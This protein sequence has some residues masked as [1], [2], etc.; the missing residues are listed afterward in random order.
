MAVP[1]LP[2]GIGFL[3]F[4]NVKLAEPPPN[5]VMICQVW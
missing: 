4:A 1:A 3:I 2:F 5:V